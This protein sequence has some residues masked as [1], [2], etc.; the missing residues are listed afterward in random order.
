MEAQPAVAQNGAVDDNE[1]DLVIC[2]GEEE[3]PQ[4]EIIEV[5]KRQKIPGEGVEQYDSLSKKV[6][7]Q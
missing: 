3:S 6:K 4:L 5:H 2:G 1:S 7:P